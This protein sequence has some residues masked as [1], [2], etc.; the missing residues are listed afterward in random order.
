VAAGGDPYWRS[1]GLL[2]LQLEGLWLGYS[3]AMDAAGAT[4]SVSQLDRS[5]IT[6]L[7]ANGAQ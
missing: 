5:S 6:F 1:V 4:G 7:N 3:A 2:L